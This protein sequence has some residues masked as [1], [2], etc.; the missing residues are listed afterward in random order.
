MDTRVSVQM[1]VA[2]AS[3]YFFSALVR[4]ITAI[5][6]PALVQELGLGAA[7]LGLLSGALFLGF[8]SVQ[9]PL[10]RWLDRYGPRQVQLGLLSVAGLGCLVFSQAQSFAGLFIARVLTG[11]GV[12]ACLM[13][14]LTSYRRWLPGDVQLRMNSWMLMAASCGLIAS[15]LPIQW[16]MPLTGWRSLFL[17]LVAMVLVCMLLVLRWVPPSWEAKGGASNPATPQTPAAT[18][19]WGNPYFRRMAPLGVFNYGGLLAIQTLWAG[20]WMIKVT[21]LSSADA[22]SGLFWINVAMLLTYMGWGL[23]NPRLSRLG[24]HPNQLVTWGVP[25]SLLCL[26]AIC[27]AGPAMPW[28]MWMVYLMVNTCV[29]NVP[30]AVG[31][32]FGPELAGRALTTFNLLI[33]TGVFAVQ[34]GLGVLI[35][36]FAAM[37]VAQVLA[38]QLSFGVFGACCLL[39]YWR[40]LWMGW[41][42]APA[43]QE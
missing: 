4:A 31:M 28:W 30:P 6:S 17:G 1:F 8:A 32:A 22:A 35:D 16:L 5:L 24:V 19:I 3:A 9:W 2:F 11:V 14:A 10:G 29:S 21:G 43:A 12:S 27:I 25:L 40:F 23:V 13:A 42:C 34:W 18:R 38:Y 20:P 33:F 36:F 26:G 15:T 7:D 37:G 39:A 41:F